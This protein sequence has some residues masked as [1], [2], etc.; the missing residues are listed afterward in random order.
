MI[1]LII[2]IYNDIYLFHYLLNIH[3][4]LISVIKIIIININANVNINQW[5]LCP[6]A[7]DTFL[8]YILLA[9]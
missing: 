6:H 7:G 3:F 4:V 5:C 8:G 1:Y 9:I 2:I